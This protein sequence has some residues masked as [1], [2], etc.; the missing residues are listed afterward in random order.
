VRGFEHLAE[1]DGRIHELQARGI[2]GC[3]SANEQQYS[4]T[5]SIQL[6]DVGKIKHEHAETLELFDSAPE[7]VEGGS[8][9]HASSAAYDGYIVQ[10]F[11]LVLKFHTSI[12]TDLPGK[13]F[14]DR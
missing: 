12:H 1:K 13:K 7:L 14:P 6:L 10:T 4:E 9:D 3:P 2:L 8:A 5:A 11:D